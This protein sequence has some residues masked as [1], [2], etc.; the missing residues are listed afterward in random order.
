[1]RPIV[2]YSEEEAK[3]DLEGWR[4]RLESGELAPVRSAGDYRQRDR[5]GRL[6]PRNI[7]ADAVLPLRL[8]GSPGL[9]ARVV[10]SEHILSVLGRSEEPYLLVMC[11]CGSE[12]IL[13]A[14]AVVECVGACS[15]WFLQA[16]SVV[17]VHRFE[18]AA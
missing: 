16:G 13:E 11:P 14:C 5:L 9:F 6:E 10:P 4:G 2:N 17:H 1:M 7:F 18:A 15:R 3:R 12:S 8:W